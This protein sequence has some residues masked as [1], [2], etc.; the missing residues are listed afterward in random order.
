MTM[1]LQLP[2]DEALKTTRA[3][4]KRLDFEKNVPIKLLKECLQLSLQSPTASGQALTHYVLIGD[5]VK[6]KKIALLYRKAFE[7]YQKQKKK[8]ETHHPDQESAERMVGSAQYLAAN[9]HKV[10]WLLIPVMVGRYN[11]SLECASVYGSILPSVWS[12]ML[13][14]RERGLGTCWTTLHIMFEK[15]AAELLDVPFERFT[16]VAMIPV[17]FSK[18]VKFK[19]APRKDLNDLLH[20]DSW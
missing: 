1:K 6:K 2:V 11:T 12:F 16:Q 10:P 13:A 3:V 20:I 17:A 18:G 7:I 8:I 15:E 5:P 9:M 19:E 4:R 14:A